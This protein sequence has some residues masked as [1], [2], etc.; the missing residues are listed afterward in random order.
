MGNATS[1]EDLRAMKSSYSTTHL[2]KKLLYSKASD[3]NTD[4]MMKRKKS[5]STL[6]LANQLLNSKYEITDKCLR[7]LLNGTL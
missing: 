6:S 7:N 1:A 2:N 5:A 3:T 4:T